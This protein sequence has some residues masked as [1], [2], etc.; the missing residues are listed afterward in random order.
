M[1][2]RVARHNQNA[3]TDGTS[4]AGDAALF[5]KHVLDKLLIC[6]AYKQREMLILEHACLHESV[7][8]LTVELAAAIYVSLCH[9]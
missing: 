1:T 2:D 7:E 4:S 5:A 8:T 3:F 9:H 6:A